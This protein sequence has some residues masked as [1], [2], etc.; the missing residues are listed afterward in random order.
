MISGVF[1]SSFWLT[2]QPTNQGKNQKNYN[3][4][5]KTHCI[6]CTKHCVQTQFGA[7]QII[8]DTQGGKGGGSP[9]CHV[10]FF[11]SLNS[12]F[13]VVGGKIYL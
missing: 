11:S 6:Q 13:N 9:K 3:A 2:K 7:I 12:D 5:M 4:S 10:N 1:K 8:R